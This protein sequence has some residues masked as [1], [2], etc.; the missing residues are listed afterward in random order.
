MSKVWFMS[1]LHLGHKAICKYRPSFSS[2]EEHSN[3]LFENLATTVGKRDVIYLLGDVAFTKE[4]LDKISKVVCSSK[5]LICGNHDTERQI[6][7]NEIVK[8]YNHVYSLRSYKGFWLSH[9]P[10]HPD[11]MRNRKGNIHGHTHNHCINDSRYVNVCVE[12]TAWKPINFEEI[13]ERFL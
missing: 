9:C 11:E 6:T 7:M 10:I 3:T 2:E 5:V 12:H 1:D 4:W 8:A 13:K